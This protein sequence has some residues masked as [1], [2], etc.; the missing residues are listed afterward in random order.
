MDSAGN[1]YITGH[2]FSTDFPTTPGASDTTLNGD[3]D[4]FVAK[5][6]AAG[7]GLV[8]STYLG[9]DNWDYGKCIAIDD[10][11]S[12]YVGG[13]THGSFP[14][15]AGAAQTVFGGMGDGFATKLS[16]DGHAIL[17][18]TYLGGNSW[19]AIAGIA[20]D[21]T[22]HAHLAT[23]SA[24]AD[25]PTTPGAYDRVAGSGDAAVA[26][27]S[28]DGS[29]FDYSTFVGGT[30]ASGQEWFQDVAVDGVG[31]AY[32]IGQSDET[33]FPTT[34][35]AL[36]RSLSGG[37]D[38]VVVK[39]NADGSGLLYSTYLGGSGADR[40]YGIA[41]D[42]TGNAYI[43]GRTTSTNLPTVNPLQAANA[44]GYDAFLA[45]VNS[46]AERAAL[47]LVSWRQRR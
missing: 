8:Y 31:N 28:A 24:S 15:T 4:G 23:G 32:L 1:A 37:A 33:D 45:V 16:P 22:G 38:A 6:N 41:I 21:H 36:L 42:E 40:G 12:A 17:Y 44:G 46:D 3:R 34:P 10:S 30:G 18:S 19:E 9:G 39:L 13:F 43:T 2:T 20:V 11:G 47:Q 27:L 7:N 35:N 29:K 5:L 14:V 26:K 25:F